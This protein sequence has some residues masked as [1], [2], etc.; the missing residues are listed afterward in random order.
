M[1]NG[2]RES[3]NMFTGVKN[4]DDGEERENAENHRWGRE[5][6]QYL[7]GRTLTPVCNTEQDAPVGLEWGI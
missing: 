7:G 2:Q 5:G 1:K 6:R 3:N 4:F